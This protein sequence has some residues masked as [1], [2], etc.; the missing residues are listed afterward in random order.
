MESLDARQNGVQPVAVHSNFS[1]SYRINMPD[2][3]SV[4]RPRGIVESLTQVKK[5]AAGVPPSAR[6]PLSLKSVIGFETIANPLFASVVGLA[7][8]SADENR[9]VG[10]AV[11]TLVAV[12][13]SGKAQTAPTTAPTI[14]QRCRSV[15][16]CERGISI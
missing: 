10:P 11:M 9:V 2:L 6:F 13:E 4:I 1:R 14:S 5:L 16:A 7:S 12:N 3:N 15:Q 8:P